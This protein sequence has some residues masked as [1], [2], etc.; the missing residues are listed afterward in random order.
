MFG[1]AWTLWIWKRFGRQFAFRQSSST[2]SL[3]RGPR[4]P[5]LVFI[6]SSMAFS[7]DNPSYTLTGSDNICNRGSGNRGEFRAGDYVVA[8]VCRLKKIAFN[9]SP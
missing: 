7:R 3:K 5:S 6:L 8:V 2:G 9:F 4:R 1:G